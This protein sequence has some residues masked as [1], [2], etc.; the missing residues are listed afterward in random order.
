MTDPYCVWTTK[1]PLSGRGLGHVT[2]FRNFGTNII[3]CE[4]IELSA[5]N[6]VQTEAVAYLGFHKGKY[7]YKFYQ[8]WCIGLLANPSISFPPLP[9]LPFPSPPL[10]SPAL[11]SRP[12][13]C[14]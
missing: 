7:K 13:Y 6:F 2:Q 14:G 8:I 11:R 12:P 10:P 3:T 9:S 5:S 4:G 1:R